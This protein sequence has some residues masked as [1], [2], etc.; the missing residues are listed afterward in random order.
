MNSADESSCMLCDAPN[1]ACDMV[2]CDSCHQWAHFFCVGVTKAIEDRDWNCKKCTKELLVPKTNK[3]SKRTGSQKSK[4]YGGSE[5][6]LSTSFATSLR[7]LEEEQ[8]IKEKEMAEEMILQERRLEMER[9]LK[10]KKRQMETKLPEKRLSQERESK[11]QQLEEERQMLERQLEEEKTFLEERKNMQQ[12]FQAAK[13]MIA[14]KYVRQGIT[15][16]KDRHEERDMFFGEKIDFWM[17]KQGENSRHEPK[18]GVEEQNCIDE[19]EAEDS[20]QNSEGSSVVSYHDDVPEKYSTEE[21]RNRNRIR[22]PTKLSAEH[23]AARQAISKHL[24]VFKG[25][26]EVWPIF[27]SSFEFTTEACGFSNL[28]NLKRLQDSLQ[29]NALEAVRSRLVLPSSVP[30]VIE[31]LRR[32]FGNRKS[33]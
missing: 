16:N 13:Q 33:C 24:P 32:L 29:G 1:S 2:Q 30:D 26:P 19:I 22:Q 14:E 21:T 28:D 27:I 9:I 25:E 31:D 15:L 4:S 5:H 17:Q 3:Q 12:E 11:K 20:D 7:K 8:R 18:K 6:E 10:E 23:I